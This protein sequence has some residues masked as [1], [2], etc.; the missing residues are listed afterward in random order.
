[1]TR[2]FAEKRLNK[3]Y[4][5]FEKAKEHENNREEL[6]V[7]LVHLAWFAELQECRGYFVRLMCGLTLFFSNFRDFSSDMRAIHST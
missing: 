2:Q 5:S 7:R 3:L 4:P 6:V 1:M